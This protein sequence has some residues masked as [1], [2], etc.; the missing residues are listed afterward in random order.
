M[1]EW[2]E[3]LS[4]PIRMGAM[5]DSGPPIPGT[6]SPPSTNSPQPL[7]PGGS[8][9]APYYA[10]IDLGTLGGSSSYANG[11]N[12][13]GQVVGDAYPNAFLYINNSMQNLGLVS[14]AVA[15]SA[16]GINNAGQ[17]VGTSS[18]YSGDPYVIITRAFFYDNNLLSDIGLEENVRLTQAYGINN[19]GQIVGGCTT[20]LDDYSWS[21]L[22][23]AFLYTGSTVT[24]LGTL[25][26]DYS[27]A[28][29][30]ND[31]GQI[32]GDSTI[33]SGD[34][35]SHAFLYE[36]GVMQDLGT[37]GGYLSVA[38]AIDNG[39]DVV[40]VADHIDGSSSAFVYSYGAMQDLGILDGGS[41]SEALGINSSGQIVG[42]TYDTNGNQ[43][44]FVYANSTMTDL[45]S[46][47]FNLNSGWILQAAVGI[48][49]VGQIICNGIDSSGQ[50]HA[51]LLNPLPPGSIPAAATVKTNLPTYPSVPT[52][53][54]TGLVFITH[55]WIPP[56][57]D[58]VTSTA[59]VNQMSNSITQY[60]NDN[61]ISDWDV[62][63]YK[64]IDGASVNTPDVALQDA[65]LTGVKIG[66]AIVNM[67]SSRWTN[68]HFIA[69][70]AGAGMIQKATE[71][72]KASLSN[73]V[74][75]HCTFLDAYDG[76]TSQMTNE[77]GTNTDWSDSYF[78]RDLFQQEKLTGCPLPHAYNVDVTA[79]DPNANSQ[80]PWYISDIGLSQF[81]QAISDHSW[82][83][84][85]Y[86][87]SVLG[88][89]NVN[90]LSSIPFGT[91]YDGFGFPLS[92]EGG[93]WS[94]AL[95]NYPPGNGVSWGYVTT[96]GPS[97]TIYTPA[98]TPLYLGSVPTF[99]V[100]STIQSTT[101]TIS[102]SPGYASAQTG[103]P[104]WVSTVITDTNALNYV[105]FNAEF[106]SAA[107]ADGLL[108]VYWDTNMI[109]EVDEAAVQPGLQYY[110]FSFPNTAP[111]TSHVLGF[112]VDPFT[113][114]HSSLILTNIVT[115]SVG[116]AQPF[117]L[118]ITMNKS[119]GLLV[120][121]LA[122]PLGVYSVQSSGDL[123]N[124]STIAYLANT[125]GT[126]NF[127]D[128]NSTNYPCQ[129]YRA[130]SPAGLSQ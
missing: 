72:I 91:N 107:G 39:G 77:Y 124:W 22:Y 84:S 45:N 98:N 115:G 65:E 58:P 96:L 16:Y 57:Y 105:S 69:H 46:L 8:T 49:D 38:Y 66:N 112:H 15:A 79:L 125:N 109:G 127:V 54:K 71:V 86:S 126:V 21:R 73:E 43:L 53:Q 82:P 81:D 34:S 5:D 28:L 27:E 11:I 42:D 102:T 17:I 55:G 29:G 52:P 1:E 44:A 64:W 19:V 93:N 6:W 31:N 37:F 83:V 14:N 89:I 9:P 106:T 95:E 92:V 76:K 94:Y 70:S 128:Q 119:D 51:F 122:G 121:Q 75:I 118:S 123:I 108:T 99:A 90:N 130:T 59:W 68:I 67:G 32:V 35:I 104:V 110:V 63:G 48:N 74:T 20:N 103:S 120:Y 114:V 2:L 113:A 80:V 47:Q 85:F 4:S 50:S 129:F 10:V 61:G 7:T 24:D 18:M 13:G 25:G 26:G 88:A 40:G 116:V 111:N 100:A 56:G 97:G 33:T 78:I 12:N 101:G 23:H 41:Y 87:N 62:E 30:I 60:L 3:S 117:S 36:N